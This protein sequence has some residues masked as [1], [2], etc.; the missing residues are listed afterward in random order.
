[1][2][3]SW[4][5]K[6]IG[7]YQIVEHLGRGGMAEVYKAYQPAL[8]RHVAVKILHP[9]VATDETFLARFE[10]E[11]RAVA[12]LRHAH[13][14]RVFDFGREDDTY[15]MVMEF[16]DG[17]TLKQRLN[18]LRAA[19]QVMSRAEATKLIVQTARG[20]HH[21]HRRGLIHRD[22][23][24][25]NILLTSQGDA[26]LSDFGIAHMVE[27]TRY[28]M[29]GVIGTPDYMSPEQGQGMEVDLRSDLYSLGIVLYECLTG[30]TPFSAD[31]PVAVIFKH[32]QDPLPMPRSINPSITEPVERAVI[33][34][35]TK[36]PDDRFASAEEMA[37]ALEAAQRG[38]DTLA[39]EAESLTALFADL[40]LEMPQEL[41]TPHE[42]TAVP[43]QETA[44]APPAARPEAIVPARR[45]RIW[46]LLLLLAAIA[47][48]AGGA[49]LLFR[50]S[51]VEDMPSQER[52]VTVAEAVGTAQSRPRRDENWAS[53]SQGS[54][55]TSGSEVQTGP[56]SSAKLALDEALIRLAGDSLLG[57][58]EIA[59]RGDD[60]RMAHFH[61]L[62]GRLWARLYA[63]S[64]FQ[65][66][67]PGGTVIPT[68]GRFSLQVSSD[69]QV[70][71][72]VEE[73]QV[74]LIQGQG[75]EKRESVVTV[76]QQLSVSAGGQPGPLQRM[77]DE[78]TALW[79]LMAIGP[80]LE[81]ATPTPTDTATPTNTPTPSPTPSDTPT[82]TPTET[83]SPSPSPTDTA[84]ATPTATTSPT[85]LPTHTPT[86][87]LTPT[88]SPTP[89]RRPVTPTPTWT[90]TPTPEDTPTP[91]HTIVVVPL[92]FNWHPDPSTLR[93]VNEIG[94]EEW[95]VT[96][97]IEPWGGDG[98]YTYNWS[99]EK[100]VEQRFEVRSRACAPIA[101]GLIVESGDGQ[102]K[103][104]PVWIEPL[105]NPAYCQ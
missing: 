79:G 54:T 98:N 13:I 85:P 70:F 36:K 22:I 93:V 7:Q 27:A 105:Y 64:D 48:L 20:L 33:K 9:F 31:T 12:A 74:S 65:I 99:N 55:F 41:K 95:V 16:V 89:T 101:G 14:V 86:T 68:L 91:T 3:D 80:D 53:V 32:V 37:D 42:A 38:E 66:E 84:T 90:P 35:L 103:E 51:P 24:P 21:A 92:D 67:T 19:G 46:P 81:L 45:R 102:I 61:L 94:V 6:T 62:S 72:S 77:S 17:Q 28:T 25:A 83:P 39:D 5:G 8:D 43:L 15:Y 97:V 59:L 60:R 44:V 75:E 30:R 88:P 63:D 100:E 50:P 69:G 73:G 18:E 82:A 49:Y 23:K 11:A 58:N 34:A 40:G 2:E 96:V 47:A 87:T 57:V 78:E 1:M 71:L 56:D 4:I 26:V 104:K 52:R 29:T 10:R 76:G